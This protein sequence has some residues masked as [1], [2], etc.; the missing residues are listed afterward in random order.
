MST[1]IT[2]SKTIKSHPKNQHAENRNAKQFHRHFTVH[3]TVI[4]L[5]VVAA[6]SSALWYTSQQSEQSQRLISEHI[7]P[8]KIQLVQQSYLINTNKLIADILQNYDVFQVISKQESLS[9]QSKKLS[10]LQS[11]HQKTYQQWFVDNDVEINLLKR[12]KSSHIE[13]EQLKSKT[14]IQLDTLLDAIDIQL[15]K[16]ENSAKSVELLFIIKEKLRNFFAQLQNLGLRSSFNELEDL[17]NKIDTI[18]VANYS[19]A[20][21][22]QGLNSQVMA[23]IVRDLILLEDMVLKSDL[24]AKWRGN[25]VLMHKYLH[26]IDSQQLELQ[27]ILYSLS[28][29][30]QN[31]RTVINHDDAAYQM[32][33][34]IVILFISSL[35]GIA[36]LLCLM[37]ARI[38]LL[39][40]LNVDC[41]AYALGTE[42]APLQINNKN[43]FSYFLK[44]S[45]YSVETAL[46]LD[47]IQELN[48]S[49]SSSVKYLTLAEEN[50]LLEDKVI[51]GSVEREQLK[52]ELELSE[53]NASQKLQSQLLF[54]QLR[55][56]GLE[57][58]AIK[59]LILLGSSAVTETVAASPAVDNSHLYQA[60]LNCRNL[61]DKLR[62]GSCYAYIKSDNSVMTLSDVS[63][64]ALIQS[65]LLNQQHQLF[66]S[67]STLS[68][69]IDKKILSEVNLDAE[70]FRL[71][72]V[73]F[74]QLL[75]INQKRLT[76]S[77]NL[78]L[79]DKN[80]GQQKICFSAQIKAADKRMKLP[81][82]LQSLVETDAEC[83][84]LAEQFKAL[85][86]YLHGADINVNLTEQGYLCSFTLPLAIKDNQ[87]EQIHSLLTLPKHI[88]EI[89]KVCDKLTAKYLVMPI[90]VLLAVKGPL[91]YQRLQELLQALGLQV[92][93]VSCK[94]A[95]EKSW[96]CG[97]YS[98]LIT[99]F[100]CLPFKPFFIDEGEI[101]SVSATLARG[102]FSLEN[103]IVFTKRTEKHSHW[104]VGEL[105]ASSSVDDLITAMLPWLKER[106]TG[107]YTNESSVQV[108]SIVELVDKDTQG[109]SVVPM[110][111]SDS[112]SF[113]FSDYLQ[114][115]GSAELA[116]YML[117]EYTTE[118]SIL[119]EELNQAFISNN[120]DD[121]C[122]AITGL[123]VNGKILAAGNLLHLCKHWQNL[124]H[125][126]M[127]NNSDKRQKALLSQI[128][129]AVQE[130][131]Q[132]A[133]TVA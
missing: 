88:K 81:Q 82:G 53:F 111:T 113:N 56:Q 65:I 89:D 122:T 30:K 109:I 91:K 36:C 41:I 9:L 14:V 19:R 117:A 86:E 63:L 96:Y 100:D 54:E 118:N 44:Q 67:E 75:S 13:N 73:A 32:P 8:L 121:A 5:L 99:E 59:Q 2:A 42:S 108:S 38:K 80:K 11:S 114:H 17:S 20:L 4:F 104:V 15:R 16:S 116:L 7:S 101:N 90:E 74:F 133:E 34:W 68:L 110:P 131:N 77:L 3:T 6:L 107:K 69:N 39:H 130:I 119:V 132:Q 40:K 24:L 102:V 37:L 43:R 83:S 49:D 28:E 61:V 66:L 26:Q 126:Q 33:I 71:M 27:S 103:S 84:E 128:K 12:I 57:E 31:H 72:F 70:L 46:L 23:D 22:N 64:I 79:V 127:L 98:V 92:T 125:N 50:Q 85:L 120:L 94:L 93:F 55:L 123:R 62:Y 51:N 105:S 112:P 129:K 1:K 47:K 45:S 18:F 87:Q 95:L 52:C 106:I 10:L 97:R 78:T 35:S 124:L 29:D 76:I 60:H 25:L 115:Q 48:D 21:T 58:F